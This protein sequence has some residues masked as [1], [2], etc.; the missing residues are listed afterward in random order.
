MPIRPIEQPQLAKRLDARGAPPAPST[1]GVCL[2]NF[3]TARQTL[4]CLDSLN[5]STRSPGL[6]AVLDNASTADDFALLLQGCASIAHSELRIYR[7]SSNLG[8]AA[9]SNFLIEVLLQDPACRHVVMINNDAV[10]LPELLQRLVDA[11]EK[12]PGAA[13]LAGARM[14]VLAAPDHVDALGIT[15]YA[16]LMPANRR[17]PMEPFLGPTG[18]CCLMTRELLD[19]LRRASGYWFDE[20]FFCYCEDTDVALRAILLGYSPVYV[21]DLL[22][23]HE[24]Q[25]SAGGTGSTFIAYHGLRNLLWMHA[26]LVPAPLIAKYGILLCCAHIL[27]IGRYLVSGQPGL[28]YRVYRDGLKGLPQFLRERRRFAREVRASWRD[29][30]RYIAPRF[31]RQ[32]YFGE[33]VGQI[34]A[35]YRA[36]FR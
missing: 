27:A 22:A 29:V 10:A 31:Y 35:L 9:G 30:D 20:R 25:A 12:A 1:V 17:D 32:G 26:K 15:V 2:I 19:A 6:V 24:G 11:I 34:A 13:G 7:A 28:V 36:R 33:V 14:H 18:G 5:A 8:F 23:L 4:R 21:D 3:N 16:S